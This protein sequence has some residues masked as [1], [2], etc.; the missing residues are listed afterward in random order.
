MEGA[1]ANQF[2]QLTPNY[3]LVTHCSLDFGYDQTQGLNEG[4]LKIW[5]F[6]QLSVLDKLVWENTELFISF[7]E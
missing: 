4:R 5:F 3:F 1:I 7:H 2:L 6:Y